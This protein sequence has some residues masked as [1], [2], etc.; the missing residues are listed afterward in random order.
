[1]STKNWLFLALAFAAGAF[2]MHYLH[3]NGLLGM[4]IEDADVEPD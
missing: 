1:M 4:G 2:A 3:A